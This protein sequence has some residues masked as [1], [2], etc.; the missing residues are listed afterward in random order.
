[1]VVEGTKL[2]FSGFQLPLLSALPTPLDGFFQLFRSFISAIYQLIVSI[3]IFPEQSLVDPGVLLVVVSVSLLG[4]LLLLRLVSRS[5]RQRYNKLFRSSFLVGSLLGLVVP[6]NQDI[7]LLAATLLSF[8]LLGLALSYVLPRSRQSFF[9]RLSKARE[10]ARDSFLYFSVITGVAGIIS[11]LLT[12]LSPSLFGITL[13]SLVPLSLDAVSVLAALMEFTIPIPDYVFLNGMI[14]SRVSLNNGSLPGGDFCVKST[15]LEEFVKASRFMVSDLVDAFRLL[16]RQGLASVEK[17][18]RGEELAYRVT[19]EGVL[20]LEACYDLVMTRL[21]YEQEVID[22]LLSKAE[23]GN[24]SNRKTVET[25]RRTLHSVKD[26]LKSAIRDNYPMLEREWYDHLENR[27]NW[28]LSQL[29][30]GKP[31]KS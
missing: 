7:G 8:L 20:Y 22:R 23:I 11:T 2:P 29:G 4:I 28:D 5:H 30:H 16:C 15:E 17:G 24:Y 21:Q 3:R 10:H 31:A 1:M 9:H 26:M 25:A 14:M 18:R 19:H 6:W 12:I 13:S 27:V